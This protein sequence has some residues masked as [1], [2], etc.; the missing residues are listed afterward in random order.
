MKYLYTEMILGKLK[1]G[2]AHED[3][4]ALKEMQESNQSENKSEILKELFNGAMFE[5]LMIGFELED[6]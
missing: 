5:F 3:S 4:E 1:K 6:Q 2:L